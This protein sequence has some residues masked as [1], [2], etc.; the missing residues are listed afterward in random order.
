[1]NIGSFKRL[2]LTAGYLLYL[3]ELSVVPVKNS[4]F[5]YFLSLL[6]CHKRVIKFFQTPCNILILILTTSIGI[7]SV[8]LSVMKTSAVFKLHLTFLLENFLSEPYLQ[9]YRVTLY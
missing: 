6:L 1:M 9:K 5:A 4:Y 3:I 7:F 2:F 8:L